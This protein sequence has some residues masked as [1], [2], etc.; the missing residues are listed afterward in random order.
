VIVFPL[1]GLP[2]AVPIDFDSQLVLVTVKVENKGMDG[3][4]TP[5]FEPEK[6]LVAQTSP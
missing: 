5:E 1:I 6:L 4:L 3:M 2:V